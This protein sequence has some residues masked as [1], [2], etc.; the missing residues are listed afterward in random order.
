MMSVQDNLKKPAFAARTVE[1]LHGP[2]QE[3]LWKCN[4]EIVQL[5]FTGLLQVPLW[6]NTQSAIIIC[7]N[8]ANKSLKFFPTCPKSVSNIAEFDLPRKYFK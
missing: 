8:S 3:F 2:P 7:L 1:S 4:L 6:S 5:F